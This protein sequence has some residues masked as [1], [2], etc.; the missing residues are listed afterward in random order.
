MPPRSGAGAGRIFITKETGFGSWSQQANPTTDAI[1]FFSLKFSPGYAGDQTVIAVLANSTATYY[2]IG[3]R[4]IY[5]NAITSWVYTGNG[6]E[7]V[8]ATSPAGASPSFSTLATASLSMPSD[9]S[10][11]SPASGAP[12]SASMCLPL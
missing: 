4:D 10:G 9:F 1:D 12:L 8:A 5:N 11:Q 3:V 7:V 2:N 6:I